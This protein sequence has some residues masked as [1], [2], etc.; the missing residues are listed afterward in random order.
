MGIGTGD[1]LCLIAQMHHLDCPYLLCV[2]S[3]VEMCGNLLQA[4]S[5]SSENNYEFIHLREVANT[6]E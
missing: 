2:A 5:L 1:F 4:I 3:I 6:E